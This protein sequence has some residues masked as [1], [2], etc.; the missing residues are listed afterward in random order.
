MASSIARPLFLAASFLSLLVVACE[1]KAPPPAPAE[2]TPPPAPAAIEVTPALLE[3]GEAEFTMRCA[4]C[5]GPDGRGD[6][7]SSAT[8]DPKPRNFHDSEWQTSV[9]DEHIKNAIVY[10]GAAVGKSPQMPSNPDLAA[11]ETTVV[12]LRAY[13]R[14]LGEAP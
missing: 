5:H 1:S 7:P 9:S 2:A 12:S 11:D 4:P 8:L 10:G 13:I 6:G 14:T 3:K